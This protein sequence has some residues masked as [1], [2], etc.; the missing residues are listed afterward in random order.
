MGDA[1]AS[2]LGRLALSPGRDP[3]LVNKSD[4]GRRFMSTYSIHT[5]VHNHIQTS[6]HPK[7]LT[8]PTSITHMHTHDPSQSVYEQSLA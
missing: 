1:R 8:H 3:A 5:C 2:W 7:T 6:S 4:Q